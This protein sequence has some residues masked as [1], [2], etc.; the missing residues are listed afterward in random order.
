MTDKTL[1]HGELATKLIVEGCL[2]HIAGKVQGKMPIE[3][4]ILTELDRT[5]LDDAVRT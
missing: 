4:V 5:D 2:A 1:T 3:P